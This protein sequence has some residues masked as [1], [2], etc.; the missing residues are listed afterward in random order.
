MWQNTILKVLQN[1]WKIIWPC[2]PDHEY[3]QCGSKY[4]GK[5]SIVVV[6]DFGRSVQFKLPW[7]TFACH[8]LPISVTGEHSSVWQICFDGAKT[9]MWWP[10][11]SW[12]MKKNFNRNCKT[13][14]VN[15]PNI[16]SAPP[17][18]N[19]VFSKH[20]SLLIQWL[21]IN[22]KKKVSTSQCSIC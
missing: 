3:I 12:K 4:C 6:T 10:A 5:G 18:L 16:T 1:Q 15:S 22:C 11:F 20:L 14:G 9:K 7:Q 2:L 8:T 19:I 17:P 21:Q 13:K